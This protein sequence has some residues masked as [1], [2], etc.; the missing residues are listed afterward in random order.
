LV[1]RLVTLR[2]KGEVTW[3]VVSFW[4]AG[5]YGRIDDAAAIAAGT[6]FLARELQRFQ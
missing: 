1:T 6:D 3:R 2:I 5:T 4:V